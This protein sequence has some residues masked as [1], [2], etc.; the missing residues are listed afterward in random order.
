MLHVTA[1]RYTDDT[2]LSC[3]RCNCCRWRRQRKKMA[4]LTWNRSHDACALWRVFF[5]VQISVRDRMCRCVCVWPMNLCSPLSSMAEESRY[6]FSMESSWWIDRW[7]RTSHTDTVI[8]Q[9][10]QCIVDGA[11]WTEL[12][13]S[14][15]GQH[16]L[17]FISKLSRTISCWRSE[18]WAS[19]VN[20]ELKNGG[21][22]RIV[23]TSLTCHFWFFARM[24]FDNYR[25]LPRSLSPTLPHG[26][27]VASIFGEGRGRGHG[28]VMRIRHE[29]R[30]THSSR[31]QSPS[32]S[33]LLRIKFILKETKSAHIQTKE[34]DEIV[35]GLG[36]Q[37]LAHS[38][39]R[40]RCSQ[41]VCNFINIMWIESNL[42]QVC[43]VI[44]RRRVAGSVA[45]VR[46]EIMF[47]VN[48]DCFYV[49]MKWRKLNFFVSLSWNGVVTTPFDLF[50]TRWKMT[51]E[52][53]WFL[54]IL[55]VCCGC[56][57]GNNCLDA[58]LFRLANTNVGQNCIRQN[59]SIEFFRWQIGHFPVASISAIRNSLINFQ[60][61]N[62]E[63]NLRH[64]PA[65]TWLHIALRQMRLSENV[66]C[67]RPVVERNVTY[68][69]SPFYFYCSAPDDHHSFG[70]K[71]QLK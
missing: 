21:N 41:R 26:S 49:V 38:Q 32:S 8:D 54:S 16:R 14:E 15:S 29:L 62:L 33:D 20:V 30:V 51:N 37:T 43:L 66:K 44:A 52:L 59:I 1:H 2:I 5:I 56:T 55:L 35:D 19:C 60:K 9:T 57:D 13:L 24:A 53:T 23:I 70:P 22:F 10:I 71:M 7:E 68:R 18:K 28:S 64:L 12:T 34:L 50:Q 63:L 42:L 48:F 45:G 39:W 3:R 4:I 58:P 11:A 69:S 31:F 65:H 17:H 47:F 61:K 25:F 67:I 36:Q 40:R 27:C 6:I 46:A